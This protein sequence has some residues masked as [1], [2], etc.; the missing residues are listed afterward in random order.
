MDNELLDWSIANWR[1]FALSFVYLNEVRVPLFRSVLLGVPQ[2]RAG[3]GLPITA[4]A[5]SNSHRLHL[6]QPASLHPFLLFILFH[7]PAFFSSSLLLSSVHR[8]QY[9]A[10]RPSL[11]SCRLLHDSPCLVQ[12]VSH[13]S[14]LLSTYP[15]S[16]PELRFCASHHLLARRPNYD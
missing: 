3:S 2:Q 5:P 16:N 8:S 7:S 9:S 13:Q 12:S 1:W 6:L 14:K 15:C 11:C 10:L 4:S